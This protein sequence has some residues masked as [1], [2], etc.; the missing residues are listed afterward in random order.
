[1][2][3]GGARS[4]D[5]VVVGGGIIGAACA[6]E[7][8]R[9]GVSVVL[10]EREELAV[11]ASGRNPGFVWLHTRKPGTQLSLARFSRARLE[12]LPEELGEDFGFRPN[13]GLIFVHTE[14]QLAVLKEFVERRRVDGVDV[15]LLS[16]EETRR[17]APILPERVAGASFC[18]ED[19][20][21]TTSE[22]VRALA[23]AAERHGAT[24]LRG[25]EVHEV[26][27]TGGRTAGVQTSAGRIDA[28]T[29]VLTAGVW[30]KALAAPLGAE[31]PIRPMRL[32]VVATEPLPPMLDLL[33]Y[34]PRSIRQYDLFHDLPSYREELF[35]DDPTELDDELPFL[36]LACQ[37]PEGRFLLGCPMDFPGE[38]WQPDL[39]GVG[40]I[41][42][43]LVQAIP[44]LA[45]VAFER[46]WAGLLPHMPDG[47]PVVDALREP[48]GTY[49]AAGHV[50][51]NSSALATAAIVTAMVRGEPSPVDPD[52]LAL[53]RPSLRGSGTRW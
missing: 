41:C 35:V 49:V 39:A 8:S 32:Q 48:T 28:G 19:A 42:R 27:T 45:G 13:G 5:V 18:R 37:T 30:T 12:E 31:L 22:L 34:G 16:G 23:V 11:G 43:Y 33:L 44:S 21:I 4:A 52:E 10:C 15:E 40:A 17:L 6:Y 26:R 7:L 38:V 51:G 50:F 1:M 46:A 24:V 2:S 20:Q 14:D 36:E 47:L 53:D 29:V 3:P 25:T 9:T